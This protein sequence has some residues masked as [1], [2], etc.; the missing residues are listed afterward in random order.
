MVNTD[1]LGDGNWGV[2]DEIEEEIEEEVEREVEEEDFD[3]AEEDADSIPGKK[4]RIQM[5]NHDI[6]KLLEERDELERQILDL[7]DDLEDRR[8]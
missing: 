7:E 2:E 1:N 3:E 6:R 4:E 8:G 5:I